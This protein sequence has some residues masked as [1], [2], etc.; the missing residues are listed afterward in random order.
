MDRFGTTCQEGFN[1]F[2]LRL[3]YKRRQ[4]V[5]KV[6]GTAQRSA[7]QRVAGERKKMATVPVLFGGREKTAAVVS[8]E[9]VVTSRS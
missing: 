6:F 1:I 7:A 8:D 2:S 3:V 4:C 5:V 9:A